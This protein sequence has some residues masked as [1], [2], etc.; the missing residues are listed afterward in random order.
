MVMYAFNFYFA[1]LASFYESL[2]VS[3]NTILNHG[4][5]EEFHLLF[6]LSIVN[7]LLIPVF[8]LSAVSLL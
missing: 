6:S 8:H 1:F 7:I 2:P 5:W 4:E 3:L